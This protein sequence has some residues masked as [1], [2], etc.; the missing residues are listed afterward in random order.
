MEN[1]FEWQ[2]KYSV[3]N[4]TIDQQHQ[5]L[6]NLGK[7]IIFDDMDRAN[8]LIQELRDYASHH[9]AAEEEH[10]RQ[11]GFPQIDHHMQLHRDLVNELSVLMDKGI[12]NAKDVDQAKNFFLYWLLD[13]VMM[14]DM[15]YF[16]FSRKRNRK[17]D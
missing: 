11:I 5:Q 13:H 8:Q 12:K 6:L 16:E 9:F 7:G 4:P 1:L 17:E 2:D 10:M 15:Q 3:G 14:Q